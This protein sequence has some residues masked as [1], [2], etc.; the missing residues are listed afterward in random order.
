MSSSA[1]ASSMD[2]PMP[3]GWDDD[4][5][6][7]YLFSAFR[8]SRDVNPHDWDNKQSFWKSAIMQRCK[9]EK[10]GVID[11]ERV[12]GM[13]KRKGRIPVAVNR[14][15]V[16]MARCGEIVRQTDFES[17]VTAG[18]I[19]WGVNQVVYKPLGW[20]YGAIFK[21][22]VQSLQGPFIV[23]EVLK[24]IA[25]ATLECHHQSV[26]S[27]AL[28]RLV[29]YT[30][31]R[32]SCRS[33]CVDDNTFRLALL[34]L[35][36][37]KKI[38][39]TDAPP[40]KQV[41]KFIGKNQTR[42]SQ[43]TETEIGILRLKKTRVSL[44][45]QIEQLIC[46]TNRLQE[47]TRQCLRKGLKSSA[48]STLRRKKLAEKSIERKEATLDTLQEM[49]DRI[50]NAETDQ[51][52]MEAYKSGAAALKKTLADTGLTAESVDETMSE[53][54]E[55]MEMCSEI[56]DTISQGNRDIDETVSLD[57]GIDTDALEAELADLLSNDESTEHIPGTNDVTA[58]PSLLRD[59]PE[60]PDSEPIG[61]PDV[62][63]ENTPTLLAS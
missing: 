9:H 17:S 12:A 1:G 23:L 38:V 27:D 20:A 61:S 11:G 3:Q 50:Q 45:Q 28:D 58:R 19:S 57:S 22:N 36:K 15:L 32:E 62:T 6:M 29:D 48:K 31:L 5:R 33:T 59:L 13:F 16:E 4:E 18:W 10:K 53:V 44:K 40:E 8:E 39:V 49:M 46:D 60:V 35:R 2:T 34:Y 43:I 41:I 37:T 25:D 42:V 63:M 24:E 56:D 14:V 7:S 47:E 52:T 55:V 54:Q 26:N 21:R 30:T 51:M